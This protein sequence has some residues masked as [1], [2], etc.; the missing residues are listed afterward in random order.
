M[1]NN[2]LC[3]IPCGSAKVWDKNPQ[4]GPTPAKYV[5]TGVFAAACQ[6]YAKAFFQDWVIL[7][8]KHGFLFPEDIIQEPYNVSFINPN[9]ETIT[10]ERLR[11]Q[12][13]VKKLDRFQGITILG[14]KHYIETVKRTFGEKYEYRPPSRRMQRYRLYAGEDN[15]GFAPWKRV[16]PK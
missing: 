5:Y 6:R 11:Q 9:S 8:A 12:T 15:K 7:S 3:I 10:V 16:C 1:S 4:A 14:G 2:K 13:K